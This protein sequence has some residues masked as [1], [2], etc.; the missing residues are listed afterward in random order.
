MKKGDFFRK[1]LFLLCCAGVLSLLA[2]SVMAAAKRA[3]P[4]DQMGG[5]AQRPEDIRRQEM[6]QQAQQAASLLDRALDDFFTQINDY[7]DPGEI[8]VKS[9]AALLDENRRHMPFF[10]DPQKARYMLLQGWVEYCGGELELALTSS[11]RTCRMDA[12]NRDGWI[13]QQYFSA[14]LGKRPLQPRPPRAQTARRGGE[15]AGGGPEMMAEPAPGQLYGSAGKLDF[16][17]QSL[18]GDLIG[19]ELKPFTAAFLDGT[20]LNYQ[21]DQQVLCLL[22]WEI[23]EELLKEKTRTE[24]AEQLLYTQP[25]PGQM[26]EGID[27][28]G[29]NP[30]TAGAGEAAGHLEVLRSLRQQAAGSK[31]LRFFTVITNKTDQT[32][33]VMK[34]LDDNPLLPPVLYVHG[35]VT[36]LV[37]E[38]ATPFVLV[39]DKAGQFRFAGSARGFP[40][41]MLL[42]RLTG[43]S[44]TKD[45]S[46]AAEPGMDPSMGMPM[47]PGRPEF[48]PMRPQMPGDPN[49]PMDPNSSP[50]A[51][52]PQRPSSKQ[53]MQ[54]MQ[55]QALDPVERIPTQD[56]TPEEAC[57]VMQLA[58][59]RDFFMQAANRKFISYRKGIDLCRYVI[60][61]CPDSENAKAARRL[62]RESIPED[63]REK[64][65]LTNEELGI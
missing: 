56:L 51:P 27:A 46:Q 65:G 4:A 28:S 41:P 8:Y 17:P 48:Q 5:Q 24:P 25:G 33:A 62:M 34:Y 54:E 64:Y 61:N 13:S 53:I 3:R 21:H 2:V 45:L 23:P 10:D 20:A 63:Q 44:F 29:L 36:D 52:G 42:G 39:V 47:P 12:A 49:R 55:D 50:A 43:L 22:V 40:L 7:R 9:A 19:R 37:L 31:E 14:L 30:E 38:A 32:E 35:D 1:S 6:E 11:A 57:G 59:A 58:A 26:A 60:K 18:R 16:D 15:M